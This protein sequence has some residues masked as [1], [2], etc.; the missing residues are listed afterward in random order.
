[1]SHFLRIQFL[2]STLIEVWMLTV[3]YHM[4]TFRCMDWKVKWDSCSTGHVKILRLSD[5]GWVNFSGG[6]SVERATKHRGQDTMAPGYVYDS[7]LKTWR[8][9]MPRKF[10]RL[11]SFL[12]SR[13]PWAMLGLY[14]LDFCLTFSCTLFLYDLDS[15]NQHP[16]LIFGGLLSGCLSHSELTNAQ[17][18]L[19]G[20]SPMTHRCS[21]VRT[22]VWHSWGSR[23]SSEIRPLKGFA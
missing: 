8:N 20:P 9:E 13:M 19:G 21:W 17:E 2:A 6:R 4:I 5:T 14:L 15:N 16:Q 7:V 23:V 12:W 22:M 3:G 10:E 11:T 1:M 18:G